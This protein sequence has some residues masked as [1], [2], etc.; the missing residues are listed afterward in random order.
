[1]P[2]IVR[3]AKHAGRKASKY[4]LDVQVFSASGLPE[5]HGFVGIQVQ[6]SRGPKLCSTDEVE[7]RTE[8]RANGGTV[9]WNGAQLSMMAT[10]YA[11]KTGKAFSDKR[12]R[13][14]LIGVKPA[15]FGT[16]KR[17]T[18]EIAHAEINASEW[19][20]VQEPKS[21]TLELPMKT[22]PADAPITL[23][24]AVGTRCIK[25]VA[26]GDDDDDRSISSALTGFSRPTNSIMSEAVAEQDLEG[27]NDEDEDPLVAL[28]A[29]NAKFGLS[30]GK[31]A[32]D[33]PP[34]PTAQ[35]AGAEAFDE[36]DES[37]DVDGGGGVG[38]PSSTAGR[39]A[40]AAP[41]EAG[42]AGGPS[43]ADVADAAG[44][45][46]AARSK[47]DSCRPG[48]SDEPVPRPVLPAVAATREAPYASTDGR[49]DAHG[50]A[51]KSGAPP[52]EPARPAEVAPRE[53]SSREIAAP[54]QNVTKQSRDI[55]AS[56][57]PNVSQM[58]REAAKGTAARGARSPEV[59]VGAEAG[60][61]P[62]PSGSAELLEVRK[63]EIARLRADLRS[64]RDEAVQLKA[65]VAA[66]EAE[67]SRLRQQA[68]Q[69]EPQRNGKG[70]APE[71]AAAQAEVT[72]VSAEREAAWR[73]ASSAQ[74]QLRR[75]RD[76]KA[77]M[78]GELDA[79][80]AQVAKLQAAPPSP[81]LSGGGA[82]AA[83]EGGEG[84]LLQELSGQ[85]VEAKMAAAQYAYERD[86]LKQQCKKLKLEVERVSGG[87]KKVAQRMTSIEVKYE[88]LRQKYDTDM[89]GLIEV[90]LDAAE[91]HARVLD[92]EEQLAELQ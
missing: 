70:A 80:R 38:L 37:E 83:A 11:S 92:L 40:L 26:D 10:L 65:A 39:R 66:A 12:Y 64:S 16:T 46:A 53:I 49:G 48:T 56:V 17:S 55:A 44:V 3:A 18:R 20:A 88:E 13:I 6:L 75:A 67:S 45:A 47:P 68:T 51:A 34:A 61:P 77:E 78:Q 82:S 58:S 60:G 19:T 91:A 21:I 72:K 84:G 5:K 33:E 85:L 7:L 42:G 23:A 89:K 90:K 22:R 79:L 73:E 81:L 43:A 29:A 76:E 62:S 35:P 87:G 36:T 63:Q 71:L 14:S 1:M 30:C 9:V 28:A 25:A 52:A 32:T 24:V 15:A 86:E 74:R 27:F 2:S 50:A 69:A 31:K 59:S 4:A 41:A 8:Q 57:L 54:L